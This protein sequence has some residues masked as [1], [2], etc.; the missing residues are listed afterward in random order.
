MFKCSVKVNKKKKEQKKNEINQLFM[1]VT[2][3]IEI[4]N[5]KKK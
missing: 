1:V 3:K 2:N 4:A 5:L